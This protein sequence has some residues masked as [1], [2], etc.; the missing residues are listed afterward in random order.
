[1]I[2]DLS[3]AL[4]K[5]RLLLRRA[6]ML[7]DN[8]CIFLMDHTPYFTD[9]HAVLVRNDSSFKHRISTSVLSLPEGKG[10]P[11]VFTAFRRHIWWQT[12]VEVGGTFAFGHA[13][14]HGCVPRA[15][16]TAEFEARAVTE[17]LHSQHVSFL[18]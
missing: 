15:S 13:G 1:M 6:A 16:Q 9:T 14:R 11:H 2:I 18:L 12:P 7:V 17:S 3:T 10:Q 5:T 4:H 8:C